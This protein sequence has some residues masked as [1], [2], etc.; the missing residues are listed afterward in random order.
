[1]FTTAPAFQGSGSQRHSS[2]PA[3]L[4]PVPRAPG[5]RVSI[6]AYCRPSRK[7]G[8]IS[9][10][11]QPTL[12][13]FYQP[14]KHLLSEEASRR[15]REAPPA[16]F[17]IPSSWNRDRFDVPALPRKPDQLRRG[18]GV[19]RIA[20]IRAG[21]ATP[22]RSQGR[23]RSGREPGTGSLPRRAA[24]RRAPARWR[25]G[26]RCRRPRPSARRPGRRR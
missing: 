14:G 9:K 18:D 11:G 12:P 13:A 26:Q 3:R 16:C 22:P 24:C 25:G 21:I 15:S 2:F 19:P 8:G 17:L 10:S 7:S 20:F 6:I 5:F 23:R 4:H 1:M